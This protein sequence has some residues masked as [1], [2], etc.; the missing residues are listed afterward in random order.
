M[1]TAL[2]GLWLALVAVLILRAARQRTA[3]ERL[4]P[5]E[6]DPEAPLPPLAVIVPARNESAN[7]LRCLESLLVQ[8][9][10]AERCTLIVV[11]DDS[12]DDT[13][14][15][16]EALAESDRRVQLLHVAALPPGW[17]GKVY[18][19]RTGAAAVAAES[20]WL[21]FLDADVVAAPQALAS[22]LAL[23]KARDLDLLSL[24]PSHTLGTFA[25]RLMLPCALFALAFIQDL[26]RI[27]SPESPDAVATGQFMLLRRTAY[28][29]VGGHSAVRAALSEDRE[30][31]CLMKRS[32]FRVLLV[33]GGA[34]LRARMYDGWRTLWPGLAR[35][36]MPVL[37]GP[38]RTVISAVLIGA[39]AWLAVLLPLYDALEWRRG[40]PGASTALALA[41][42]ASAALF[43]LYIA[44][45]RHFKTAWWYGALFPIGYTAAALM[46]LDSVR[47][48]ISRRVR[49]R[50][51]V[52]ES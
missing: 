21:C 48:R 18:A 51:R 26:R 28:E 42:G 36:M 25:E 3:L 46:A 44:G 4:A 30:L 32:G 49:W 15:I 11:D 7:I 22:A 43:A 6:P 5:L 10:P 19:C 9:L 38:L 24:A 1:L 47:W 27:Q 39:L 2:S 16:V 41:G 45:A 13:A 37:G 12:S 40:M 20:E 34:L 14:R 8:H 50:G 29:A 52:Y 17:K 23:A 35:N 31:A 33:D